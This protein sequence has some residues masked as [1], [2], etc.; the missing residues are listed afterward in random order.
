MATK[1]AYEELE[2]RNKELES[3]LKEM[4]KTL[5][6]YVERN[7]LA[8]SAAKVGVWDWNIETGDFYLDPNI[9]AILGYT[10]DEI[11]NIYLNTECC[12][13]TA[14]FAGYWPGAEQFGI[15]MVMQF[16]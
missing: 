15:Q 4:E 11:P 6:V 3:R 2:L 9:K 13:R 14:P 7:K 5:D 12:I 16:D 10:D 8:T 1:S